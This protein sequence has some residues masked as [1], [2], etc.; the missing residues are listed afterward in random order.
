MYKKKQCRVIYVKEKYI[1]CTQNI[2]GPPLRL[3]MRAKRTLWLV[4]EETA[5]PGENYRLT[6]SRWQ[7]PRMPKPGF[8]SGQWLETANRKSDRG[9]VQLKG[10]S[11]HKLG[12]SL[13]ES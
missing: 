9:T 3:F 6:L 10:K 11:G 5:V 4:V 7:L 2:N 1:A 8:E 13:M 12:H